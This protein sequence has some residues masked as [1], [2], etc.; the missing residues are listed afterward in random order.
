MRSQKLGRRLVVFARA[1]IINGRIEDGVDLLARHTYDVAERLSDV[2][3]HIVAMLARK[4]PNEVLDELGVDEP[5]EDPLLELHAL[6]GREQT[7]EDVHD[8]RGVDVAQQE[9]HKVALGLQVVDEQLALRV[10]QRADAFGEVARQN[11]VQ[12]RLVVHERVEFV[13]ELGVRH[14]GVTYLGHVAC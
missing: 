7:H 6:D 9:R 2:R 12:R 8:G 3:V 5:R 4:Q 11:G 13:D 1:W 14:D 10:D